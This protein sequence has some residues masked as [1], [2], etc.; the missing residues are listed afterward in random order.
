MDTDSI[1]RKLFGDEEQVTPEQPEQF[2]TEIRGAPVK[3]TNPFD[4]SDEEDEQTDPARQ[5]FADEDD[6]PKTPFQSRDLSREVPEAPRK[7]AQVNL[8]LPV[9]SSARRALSFEDDAI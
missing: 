5:L 2:L 1:R 8:G 6:E 7:A 9:A 4:F 3:S